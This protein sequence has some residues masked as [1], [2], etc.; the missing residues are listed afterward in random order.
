M[1]WTEAD[2]LDQTGRVALV[3]GANSGLGFETAKAL[4]ENGATVVLAC[5]NPEK[6]AAAQERISKAAPG[7]PTRI[8]RRAWPWVCSR[9]CSPECCSIWP[10]A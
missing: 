7:A 5:R 9:S 8:H 6:A 1:K 2:I 3:T 10:S 4:A